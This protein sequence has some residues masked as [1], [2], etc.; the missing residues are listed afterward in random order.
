MSGTSVDGLDIVVADFD[1][2]GIPNLV[3]SYFAAYPS[4]L[5]RRIIHLQTLTANLLFNQYQNELSDLDNTLADFYSEHINLCLK[6]A[7]LNSSTIHAIGNHGQ[8][9]LHQPN[10][11]PAFSLQICDPQ[12]LANQC[13]IPVIANFRQADIEQQGQGA[14][15]IPAFH[16]QVFNEY[17]PCA[18][19]N[20]GGIS[21][22]TFLLNEKITGFD[23]GPGNTLMDAWIYQNQQQTYDHDGNWAQSGTVN[24]DLLTELLAHPFFQLKAPKSTGQDMFNLAWLENIL[25]HFV[26]IK[27]HDV[28]ATLCDFTAKSIANDIL[29]FKPQTNKVFVCGGGAKNSFLMHRLSFYLGEAITVSSTAKLNIDPNWVEALGFAWLAFRHS[30]NL[31]GNIPAVTGA[32][33]AVVLGKLYEASPTHETNND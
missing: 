22:S 17:K 14:P 4:R 5:R 16:S 23:H 13:D 2:N 31:N 20:I 24:T 10:S 28:Q 19:L 33:K 30:N 27:A 9:I 21:N 7:K 8:T 11:E 26:D 12:K 29:N 18:I 6:E 1:N 3:H 25:N 32:K 15:L